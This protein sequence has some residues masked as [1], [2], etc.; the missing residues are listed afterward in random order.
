MKLTAPIRLALRGT[1]ISSTFAIA[2]CC[3]APMLQA[4]SAQVPPNQL[5][6]AQPTKPSA[7][8]P[9]STRPSPTP[10]KSHFSV[11]YTAGKLSITAI[12]ASLNDILRDVSH[13]LGMKIT[14]GV[15]D[16]RVYG[17]YGPATPANVLASLLDG[18]GSN[19]LVVNG[20][21]GPTE[22]ILAPR[23]GGPTPPNPSAATQAD[24]DAGANA[25][26]Q[27][28]ETPAQPEPRIAPRHGIGH[29]PTPGAP[30]E[31][32]S[33]DSAAPP[34]DAQSPNGIKTPQQINDELRQAQQQQSAQP[35]PQ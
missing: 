35:T 11:E 28:Q 34:N 24:S 20:A 26:D 2:L 17:Q 6:P 13:T 21:K 4:Q 7:A 22:L 10:A 3:V 33:D 25:P 32:G 16:E 9:V 23:T 5:P 8:V 18:T 14:G 29:P 27:P 15:A 1:M 30:P 31:S 12:N 19:I